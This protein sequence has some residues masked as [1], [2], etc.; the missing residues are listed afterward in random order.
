VVEGSVRR[1]DERVRVVAQLVDTQTGRHVWAER[2]DRPIGELFD[3]QDEITQA[4]VG[5]LIPALGTVERERVLRK[6]PQSLG[7][8]EAYQRGLWH[9][10]RPYN[11]DD[12]TEARKLFERAIEL[13]PG[14]ADAHA[15][16]GLFD[17]YAVLLGGAASPDETLAM[18]ERAAEKAVELE[19]SNALAHIALGRVR[20]V[21]RNHESAIAEAETAVALNPNLAVAHYALALARAY[22]GNGKQAIASFDRAIQLSPNDPSRWNFFYMKSTTL[23]QLREY[24]QA[25]AAAKSAQRLRPSAFLPYT[26][27]AAALV[28]LGQLSEA[29]EAIG[30][31]RSRNPNLTMTFFTSGPQ[32]YTVFAFP[33][34]VELLRKAGL[35]D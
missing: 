2:Y 11:A 12:Q 35:P 32:R 4:V 30:E 27:S 28:G 26:N 1:S 7:A 6:P 25:L 22:A 5:T 3:L 21:L 31:A 19:N 17:Y 15:M 24:E 8:W 23:L 20:S 14:F 10:H 18:A 9:Y 13:D 33:H 16:L 29:C 34:F